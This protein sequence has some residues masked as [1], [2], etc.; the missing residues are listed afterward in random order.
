MNTKQVC[1]TIIA[2]LSV[3]ILIAMG[4]SSEVAAKNETETTNGQKPIL[5]ALPP[6]EVG[7]HA[8]RLL[9]QINAAI[10]SGR[11]YEKALEKASAEDR[12]VLN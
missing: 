10:E 6:E 12:Q 3:T 5:K 2:L 8:N 4:F 11:R 7:Q 9:L 1:M